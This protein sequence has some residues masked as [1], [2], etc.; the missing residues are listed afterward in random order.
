MCLLFCPHCDDVIEI[1]GEPWNPQ[2]ECGAELEACDPAV[3]LDTAKHLTTKA[4]TGADFAKAA[5]LEAV[6]LGGPFFGLQLPLEL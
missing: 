3:L 2:C 5:L 6:A 1:L 4:E